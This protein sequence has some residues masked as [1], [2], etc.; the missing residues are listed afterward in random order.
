MSQ[1]TTVKEVL[2]AARWIIDNIGW[3]QGRYAKTS[4][5]KGVDDFR[6]NKGDAYCS[7]GAIKVVEKSNSD[8]LEYQASC[9]FQQVISRDLGSDVIVNWNDDLHMTK[10][11]VLEVFDQAIER[12]K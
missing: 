8:M 12:A 5:G 9:A 6:R 7:L 1:A 3:C 2:I 10:Q 4:D 11:R